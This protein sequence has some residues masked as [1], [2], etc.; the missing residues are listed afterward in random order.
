MTRPVGLHSKS[1][2]PAFLVVHLDSLNLS[3]RA[4]IGLIWGSSASSN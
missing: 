1:G 2:P 3:P 4:L